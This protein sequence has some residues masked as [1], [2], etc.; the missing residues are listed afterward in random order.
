MLFRSGRAGR[1]GEAILFVAPRERNMLRIIER[2]TKQSIEQMRL[3]SVADVNEQRILKFKETVANAV[4]SGEGKVFQPLIEDIE[5]EQNLPAIELAAALASLLQG[6]APFLLTP[7]PGTPHEA[8]P[9]GWLREEPRSEMEATASDTEP[10]SEPRPHHGSRK[11]PRLDTYRIEVGHEHGVQ[12]GNI[13]GAIANEADLD[14]RQIGHIDI[15]GDHS[16][17]D[18]PVGMPQE[19]FDKLQAVRVRGVELRI[20]RV[21]SKPARSERR[22][23][24]HGAHRAADRKRKAPRPGHSAKRRGK[25][26]RR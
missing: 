1:N 12:P 7:K 4:R 16:F 11:G 10:T 5:R 2:A 8:P 9:A 23:H 21:D 26:P 25:P 22:P 14:G 19:T 24:S 20:S 17:V 18:L 3:P 6:P 13:V 15:R